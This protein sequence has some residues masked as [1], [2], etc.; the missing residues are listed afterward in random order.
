[1]AE[2]AH[3][4]SNGDGVVFRPPGAM[5]QRGALALLAIVVLLGLVGWMYLSQASEAAEL[6]HHIQDLRQRKEELQRQND[7]LT[8]EIARLAS[9]DRLDKRARDL[10][11]VA[12][13]QARFVA[14][15]GYSTADEATPGVSTTLAPR[16]PVENATPSAVAGWWQAVTDQFETWTQTEQP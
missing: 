8:Y 2:K 6:R 1:M 10:G 3:A 9:V 13:W 11:Y 4:T 12:V 16:E 5:N 14:V 15:A 7:Q